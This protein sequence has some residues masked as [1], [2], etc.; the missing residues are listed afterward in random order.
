[1]C[2]R[3]VRPAVIFAIFASGSCDP[4]GRNL[5][6][7]RRYVA[8]A[9]AR[10]SPTDDFRSVRQPLVSLR[11]LRPEAVLEHGELG[12]VADDQHDLPDLILGIAGRQRVAGGV[13]DEPP[14]VQLVR[15]PQQRRVEVVPAG[16]PE[17]LGDALDLLV[18][19]P[20]LLAPDVVP[21]PDV[22]AA[23]QPGGA[24][25]EDLL[26]AERNGVLVEDLFG[27]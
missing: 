25:D 21:P 6:P 26:V 1:M 16:R 22:V 13:A 7:H 9:N 5:S 12:V 24:E 17:A 19:Q 20:R 11:K 18:R 10:Y 15:G 14:R 27:R 8:D 23:R 4:I 3:R 2:A